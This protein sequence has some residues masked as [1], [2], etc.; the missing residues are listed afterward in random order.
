MERFCAWFRFVNY[1]ATVS[2]DLLNLRWFLSVYFGVPGLSGLG[3]LA[4]CLRVV[5]CLEVGNFF[6]TPCIVFSS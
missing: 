6:L 5:F 2:K 1:M 4:W 3:H